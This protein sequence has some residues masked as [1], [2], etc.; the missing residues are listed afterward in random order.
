[1]YPDELPHIWWCAT[2]PL[3]FLPIHAAGIYDS[4]SETERL[5]NYAIS[6]YIPTLSVLLDSPNPTPSLPFKLL[7]V[8]QSSAPGAS[9]I[10][11]TLEELKRIQLYIRDGD[12]I[13][14]EESQGTKE[15]VK[16]QMEYCSWLHLACHG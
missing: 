16:E 15:R 6:S 1:P 2:G 14:L 9:T 13:V 7:S 5:V 8:I 12:H 11:N 10:P 3:A 4:D